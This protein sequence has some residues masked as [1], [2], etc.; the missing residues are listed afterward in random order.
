MTTNLYTVP[1]VSVEPGE[2]HSGNHSA[3]ITNQPWSFGTGS[4]GYILLGNPETDFCSDGSLAMTQGQAITS[5]TG[6]YKYTAG[7]AN[8]MATLFTYYAATNDIG[9]CDSIYSYYQYLPATTDWTQFTA[10]VPTDV[11]NSWIAGNAPNH[12]T[13]GLVSTIVSD[14]T[15]PNGDANSVLLVDDLEVSY[16]TVGVKEAETATTVLYPNPANDALNIQLPRYT[17]AQIQLIDAVGKTILTSNLY[18]NTATLNTSDVPAGI[19]VLRVNDGA[20]ISTH[21]LVVEH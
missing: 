3:R 21:S 6:Y 11:I 13:V 19:Y 17:Q 7:N 15:E 12:F 1:N 10:T 5:L 16:T 18:G 9:G 4:L 8:E 2:P 20:T 14:T